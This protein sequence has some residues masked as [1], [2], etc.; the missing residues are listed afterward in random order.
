MPIWFF[1]NFTVRF[2]QVREGFLLPTPSVWQA[3]ATQRQLLG[4]EQTPVAGQR[5]PV[6]AVILQAGTSEGSSVVREPSAPDSRSL[7]H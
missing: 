5:N 1:V 4:A 6:A 7:P 3:P 2:S